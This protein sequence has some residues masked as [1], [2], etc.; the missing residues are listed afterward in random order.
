MAEKTRVTVFAL[1]SGQLFSTFIYSGAPLARD[2]T[3]GA[4]RHIISQ[5]VSYH[6]FQ[7]GGL[8]SDS[9]VHDIIRAHQEG[10]ARKTG[11]M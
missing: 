9:A 7:R 10:K 2:Y 11:D 8:L 6:L 3:W 1:V 5:G 4:Y